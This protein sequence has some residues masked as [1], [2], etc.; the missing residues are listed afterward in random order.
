[1]TAT[2]R[3][4]AMSHWN[5]T[6]VRNRAPLTS[7]SRSLRC[8]SAAEH[9]TAEQY[10]KT[11]R[12][13]PRKQLQRSDPS[14]NTSHY[15]EDTKSLRSSSGSRAKMLLKGHLGIKCE[16]QYHKVVWF[17][18]YSSPLVNGGDWGGIMR[19]RKT[20]VVL[21]LLVFNFI[22]DMSHHSLTLPRSRIKDSYCNSDAWG[23]HNSQQS[24]VISITDQLIFQ[25]RKKLQ[26]VQ[27]EL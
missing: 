13:K 18:Q 7:R 26:S 14:W 23:W 8:V 2:G 21:V 16:S 4:W 24:G 17:L 15:P 22:P 25:N 3:R 5:T 1:M 27:Q 12:T 20:I 11:G 19:N 10:S 9:H 6:T